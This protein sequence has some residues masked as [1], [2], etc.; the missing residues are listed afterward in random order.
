MKTIL[1]MSVWP[2][3]PNG[4]VL[5]YE[6][7]GSGFEPSCSHLKLFLLRTFLKRKNQY[8]SVISKCISKWNGTYLHI[9]QKHF[10]IKNLILPL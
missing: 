6:L 9:Y 1:A 3:W 5:V 2:V 8:E 4:W 7:S 10:I